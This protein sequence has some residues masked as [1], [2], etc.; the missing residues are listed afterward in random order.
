MPQNINK[1]NM[2]HEAWTM[3]NRHCIEIDAQGIGSSG[4]PIDTN[5]E[6]DIVRSSGA[7]ATLYDLK[8][9]MRQ[10]LVLF[11]QSIVYQI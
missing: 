4:Y 7:I 11:I 8:T 5:A 10:M 9:T 1:T 2:L 3:P 6:G